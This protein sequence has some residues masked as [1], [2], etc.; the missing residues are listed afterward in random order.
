[1]ANGDSGNPSLSRA[2][3]FVAFESEADN[4][5]P[6]DT[7]G[8]SDV[9]VKDLATGGV[10]RA[11]AS[12]AGDPANGPSGSP[13]L[14]ADGHRVA[15]WSDASNLVPED[16]NGA[17]DVFIRD[18][19]KGTTRRVSVSSTEVAGDQSSRYPTVSDDGRFVAFESAATNLVG[20]DTNLATDVFVRDR[21]NGITRRVSVSS[22]KEEGD[23]GGNNAFLSAS[24]KFVVF[25]S[26]S[27]NLVAN[28]TNVDIDIFRVELENGDRLLLCSDGLWGE[29]EDQEI[30]SI[31]NQHGDNRLISR[32]LIRAAH[33]GGGKDNITVILV[34]VPGETPSE[35]AV[36]E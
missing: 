27:T 10:V 3:R 33:M 5:V 32:E 2:G 15:F 8:Q 34:N 24:G 35:E 36:P 25:Q 22:A 23:A 12:E 13:S 7:N 16:T 4:L 30:E 18:L 28:D 20:S 29:V 31:L 6:G 9:F 26:S 17:S 11:S 14:S 21:A 1:M 19:L